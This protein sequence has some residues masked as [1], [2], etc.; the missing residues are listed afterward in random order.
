MVYFIG[1][2]PGDPE[3][4]TMKGKKL[5]DQ[6]DIIIYAGSLVN[7]ALFAEILPSCAIYDSSGLNLDEVL[8]IMRDAYVENKTV[9]RVH[10]GDPAIYGAI[11][12]QMD[13][14]KKFG[15]PYEVI[16]GVSSFSAAAAALQI[17]YT[18]PDVSQSLILTRAAGRTS[19]P[20]RENIRSFASHQ[21]TMVIFLSVHMLDKLTDE[22]IAGGYKPTTPAAV[23]YRA[24][25]PDQKIVRGT[26]CDISEQVAQAGI[27]RMALVIVGQVLGD[28]YSLSKL[29]DKNFTHGWR[30][31]SED[32]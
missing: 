20:E 26:L 23:V 4:L 29:Y 2:G 13:A 32:V 17:E 15:I 9:A 18:L 19:V 16:P 25:W 7:P 28:D 30:Q 3:L 5:I 21:A 14:L 27:S 1:A 8:S 11:R 24:S 6:A 22:L 10:T 31:G 12:E